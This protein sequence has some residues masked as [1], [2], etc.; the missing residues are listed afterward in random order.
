MYVVMFGNV[1]LHAG[2]V[3][4][5]CHVANHC[6]GSARDIL[7]AEN[8]RKC[9]HHSFQRKMIRKVQPSLHSRSR[10]TVFRNKI[11]SRVAPGFLMLN[12]EGGR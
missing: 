4:N 5:L 2:A 12:V 9:G 1:I 8:R 7:S 3:E 11:G 10:F 6:S